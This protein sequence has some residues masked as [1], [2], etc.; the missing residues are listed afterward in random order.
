M[1]ATAVVAQDQVP[2]QA[3]RVQQILVAVAVAAQLVVLL[4]ALVA[5]VLSLFVTQTFPPSLHNL[6]R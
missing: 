4:V 5:Q 2:P 1:A 3:Q 6:R